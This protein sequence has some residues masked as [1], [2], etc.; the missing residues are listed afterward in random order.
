M[1]LL[2][3]QGGGCVC[4]SL[5]S[6]RSARRHVRGLQRVCGPAAATVRARAI[7]DAD[8]RCPCMCQELFPEEVQPEEVLK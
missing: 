6:I 3:I 7:C 2:A 8:A 5:R 1:R 4:V